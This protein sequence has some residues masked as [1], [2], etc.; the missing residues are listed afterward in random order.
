MPDWV[1]PRS[2]STTWAPL[3]GL[4][5]VFALGRPVL[6]GASRKS[7]PGQALADPAT[8]RPRPARSRDAAMAAV[9][10]L[11]AAQGAWCLRVHDVV[12]TL[13]AVRVTTHWG[14]EP[15]VA[16]LPLQRLGR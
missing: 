1:S 5:E 15:A 8:G 3:G 12:C 10:V 2:P 13:D 16:R 14:A 7:S 9:S 11:A 6:V 4:G